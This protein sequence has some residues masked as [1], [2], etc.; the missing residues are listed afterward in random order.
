MIVKIGSVL[1]NLKKY[2]LNVE[3]DIYQ[4]SN[5]L[6]KILSILRPFKDIDDIHVAWNGNEFDMDVNV[7]WIRT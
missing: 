6:F 1:I 3:T 5:S 4:Y 7:S 2:S